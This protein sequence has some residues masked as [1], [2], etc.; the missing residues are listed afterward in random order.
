M[1]QMAKEKFTRLG[2]NIYMSLDLVDYQA[3][4]DR[5]LSWLTTVP[6][7]RELVQPEIE[8]PVIRLLPEINDYS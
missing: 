7:P 2:T 4:L 6:D 5:A 8:L 1:Y 3:Q